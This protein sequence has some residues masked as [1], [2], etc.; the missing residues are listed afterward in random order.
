[1]KC[2]LIIYFAKNTSDWKQTFRQKIESETEASFN[3]NVRTDV[4]YSWLQHT[5][6]PR[7]VHSGCARCF[8][9][10]ESIQREYLHVIDSC[11]F[12]V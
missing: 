8:D 4:G 10:R 2:I 7:C 11:P 9:E 6:D 3:K 1:M 12:T 5:L